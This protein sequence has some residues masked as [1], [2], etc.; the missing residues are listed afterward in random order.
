MY[1]CFLRTGI[2]VYLD[3]SNY[4]YGLV[5]DYFCFQNKCLFLFGYSCLIRGAELEFLLQHFTNAS[6]A[7]L[8]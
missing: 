4:M 5:S 2:V 7:C 3:F 1:V 6:K 8:A